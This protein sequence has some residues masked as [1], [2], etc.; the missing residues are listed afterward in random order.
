MWG[1]R[2][3]RETFIAGEAEP[4]SPESSE[5]PNPLS[6]LDSH[7]TAS[8]DEQRGLSFGFGN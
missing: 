4:Y 5:Q 8:K 1:A 6:E 7:A 2:Y 3:T